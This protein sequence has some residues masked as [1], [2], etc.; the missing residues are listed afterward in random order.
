MSKQVEYQI[1]GGGCQYILF[2]QEREW[3]RMQ[4]LEVD[5]K[6]TRITREQIEAAIGGGDKDVTQQSLE[7]LPFN[8]QWLTI[9]MRVEAGVSSRVLTD[10]FDR[11]GEVLSSSGVTLIR[12]AWN[13]WC[14]KKEYNLR[15]VVKVETSYTA[16]KDGEDVL[17]SVEA[18]KKLL[19]TMY[20]FN[21]VLQMTG[22]RLVDIHITVG[23]KMKLFFVCKPGKEESI[24]MAI[25]VYEAGMFVTED[26]K[27]TLQKMGV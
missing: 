11:I 3:K 12:I 25:A 19:T 2:N 18:I 24:R 23:N 20:V 4:G 10:E 1:F 21:S 5:N 16:Q 17:L 13:A 9:E 26:T 8:A 14:D 7:Q 15:D 6:P 22:A 27:I